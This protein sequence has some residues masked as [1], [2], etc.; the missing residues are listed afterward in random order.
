MGMGIETKLTRRDHGMKIRKSYKYIVNQ[1]RTKR[2][3]VSAVPYLQEL[4]NKDHFERRQ[5]LRRLINAEGSQSC[6]KKLKK[7]VNCISNV[8]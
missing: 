7:R 1:S 4:L 6:G 2:K 3:K 8:D 5:N